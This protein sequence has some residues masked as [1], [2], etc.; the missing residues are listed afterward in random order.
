MLDEFW[1][2]VGGVLGQWAN[3]GPILDEVWVCLGRGLWANFGRV[4]GQFWARLDEF[5][6]LLGQ[7]LDEFWAGAGRVL[8]IGLALDELL[9]R[10]PVD[11]NFGRVGPM[12]G[13]LG[14]VVPQLRR[15]QTRTCDRWASFGQRWAAFRTSM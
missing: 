5:Y 13:K 9:G 6:D 11:V 8:G 14:Q 2:N 4:L 10:W 3:F 15:G 12:L 7:V 1:A